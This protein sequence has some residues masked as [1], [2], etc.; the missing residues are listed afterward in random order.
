M[1]NVWKGAYVVSGY[2]TGDVTLIAT[3][4]ELPLAVQAAVELKEKGITARVVSA[5][6]LELFDRQ[7]QEYRDAILGDRDKLVAIEAGK[8]DGWWKYVSHKGLVI[9][10]D[11][12]GAS[13]P[14]E[15]LADEYRLTPGKV[16]KKVAAWWR[17]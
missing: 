16:A 5:P 17:G 6:S 1:E 14:A 10:I 13:A 8:T 3:G 2:E 7:T 15:R 9:G 4:S 12:F 11:H